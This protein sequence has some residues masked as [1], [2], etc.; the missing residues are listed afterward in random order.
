[1]FLKALK[2]NGK[3]FEFWQAYYIFELRVFSLIS[4]RQKLLQGSSNSMVLEQED[5][6]KSIKDRDFISL[7]ENQQQNQEISSY[8]FANHDNEKSIQ[9]IK[10]VYETCKEKYS[11]KN[12]CFSCLKALKDENLFNN[13]ILKE[14]TGEILKELE[15]ETKNDEYLAFKAYKENFGIDFISVFK[16]LQGGDSQAFRGF[17]KDL[18][19]KQE[20][21]PDEI[22]DVLGEKESIQAI[23]QG[24]SEELRELLVNG[25]FKLKICP[26]LILLVKS[27]EKELESFIF[28]EKKGFF[29]DAYLE[30][31]NF[32]SDNEDLI[33][34]SS[35]KSMISLLKNRSFS[36]SLSKISLE[37]CM[38]SLIKL[39]KSFFRRQN[40]EKKESRKKYQKNLIEELFSLGKEAFL[41]SQRP[42]SLFMKDLLVLCA[43]IQEK[44]L[45][46]TILQRL[47]SLKRGCPIE[48]WLIYL[49]DEQLSS[50]EK[51]SIFRL[52]EDWW[53]E[54]RDILEKHINYQEKSGQFIEL[55]RLLAKKAALT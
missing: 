54:N 47:V 21:I 15:E 32:N 31:L 39:C 11:R 48:I 8:N 34:E 33:T 41:L 5:Q 52:L 22:L 50:K 27:L 29:F 23:L 25:L 13:E 19:K 9:L 3:N 49:E 53:P 7:S 14:F 28:Q 18:F 24:T 30:I 16:K 12:A 10:I 38:F 35:L 55:Q 40:T 46:K 42:F 4:Q 20:E 43:E 1:M 2:I 44:E 45:H 51:E 6:T 26:K 17:L 36:Q 37:N